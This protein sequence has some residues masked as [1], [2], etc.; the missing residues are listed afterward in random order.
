MCHSVS[1]FYTYLFA[2]C[3]NEDAAQPLFDGH[4]LDGMFQRVQA[5]VEVPL[6][7]LLC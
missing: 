4:L 7:L 5:W 1:K 2:E 3:V 6:M